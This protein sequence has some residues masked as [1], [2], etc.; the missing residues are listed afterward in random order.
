MGGVLRQ[1]EESTRLRHEAR[2]KRKWRAWVFIGGP[3]F[4]DGVLIP[5][6]HLYLA[7]VF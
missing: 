4:E 2:E 5:D 7:L 1:F 3:A 6:W